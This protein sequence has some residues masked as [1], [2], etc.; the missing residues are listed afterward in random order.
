TRSKVST[1]CCTSV[2]PWR[3]RSRGST[4]RPPRRSRRTSTSATSRRSRIWAPSGPAPTLRDDP[5]NVRSLSFALHDREAV[6]HF[7]RDTGQ[8]ER[9]QIDEGPVCLGFRKDRLVRETLDAIT[10]AR[11]HPLEVGH[12][13]VHDN[14]ITEK[15]RLE[16]LDEVRTGHPAASQF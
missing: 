8:G 16:V 15:R 13:G 12:P 9:L 2:V 11:S 4:T 7:R 1:R 10:A 14:L 5:S 6:A 3:W